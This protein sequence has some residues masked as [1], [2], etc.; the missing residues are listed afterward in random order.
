MATLVERLERVAGLLTDSRAERDAV[1]QD[2]TERAW[3]RARA[4]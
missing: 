3:A 2:A 4:V 1:I